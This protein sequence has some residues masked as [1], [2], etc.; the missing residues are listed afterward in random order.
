MS[1][2][3]NYEFGCEYDAYTEFSEYEK[4]CIFHFQYGKKWRKKK[5]RSSEKKVYEDF[6]RCLNDGLNEHKISEAKGFIFPSGDIE[7]K[8]IINMAFCTVYGKL[9]L[10][11][12]GIQNIYACKFHNKLSM[13]SISS[14]NKLAFE[15]NLCLD[16]VFMRFSTF[17]DLYICN[18]CFQKTLDC[19]KSTFNGR[20]AIEDNCINT[21]DF[22]WTHINGDTEIDRCSLPTID[23]NKTFL[24]SRLYIGNLNKY[25]LF[26]QKSLKMFFE[27]DF[28]DDF[29]GITPSIDLKSVVIS[30]QGHITLDE[31]N[32]SKTSFW[33]TNLLKDK[34]CIDFKMVTWGKD[35]KIYD[36]TEEND[37]NEIERLYREIKTCY[38]SRSDH[39]I[40]D[41]FYVHE[42]RHRRKNT[43][44]KIGR[45]FNRCYWV[46]SKYGESIGR[47]L[48]WLGG[49]VFLTTLF[50]L[51][52]GV[53]IS[54][55]SINY[56]FLSFNLH[57]TG[58]FFED[59]W[60]VMSSAL[61]TV[62]SD[63]SANFKPDYPLCFIFLKLA[64]AAIFTLLLLSIRRRFF[65]KS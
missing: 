45:F 59:F 17:K 26:L 13:S 11:N 47:P 53:E 64:G 5:P 39:G 22:S 49:M 12:P 62:F 32:V 34:P 33:K 30:D 46:F 41:K 44:S 58:I 19:T 4:F 48:A 42:M 63:K 38:P 6:Q 54:K 65:R 23:F 2:K 10:T 51:F 40:A 55:E 50:L 28:I 8:T 18:N 61:Q 35:Y 43:K 37:S 24:S 52:T 3:C 15:Y 29:I 1:A 57:N 20:C 9:T 31:L 7:S 27:F 60:H 56:S 14:E 36:D 21:L 25:Q 16:K